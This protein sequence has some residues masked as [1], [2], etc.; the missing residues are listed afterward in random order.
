MDNNKM[1]KL[2]LTTAKEAGD[3]INKCIEIIDILAEFDSA[4][5][6]LDEFNFTKDSLDKLIMRSRELKS[7][8]VWITLK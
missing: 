7:H 2:E 1:N 8:R 5:W 6:D 4:D 3:V